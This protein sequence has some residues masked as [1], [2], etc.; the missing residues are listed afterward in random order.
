MS[1]VSKEEMDEFI[2]GYKDL[3]EKTQLYIVFSD[4]L[5]LQGAGEQ[6]DIDEA[7]SVIKEQIYGDIE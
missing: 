4:G 1:E 3:C 7:V 2:N 5:W 6:L